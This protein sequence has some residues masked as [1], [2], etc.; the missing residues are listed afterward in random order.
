MTLEDLQ[1]FI[2]QL[3]GANKIH[4]K[5]PESEV[6]QL[7]CYLVSAKS[8]ALCLGALDLFLGKAE[9][10]RVARKNSFSPQGRLYEH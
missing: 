1:S 8:V 3:Q 7:S 5:L 2:A 4:N 6:S 9:L 10:R